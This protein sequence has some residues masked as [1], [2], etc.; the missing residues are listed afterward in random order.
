MSSTIPG[1][2]FDLASDHLARW[3]G[4]DPR[5]VSAGISLLELAVTD[6]ITRPPAPEIW[7]KALE[8]GT[9]VLARLLELE[10]DSDVAGGLGARLAQCLSA[11]SG[12][13]LLRAAKAWRHHG[14]HPKS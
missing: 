14:H 1:P 12:D 3:D 8:R 13:N 9:A 6:I 7:A 4:L 5:T 10:A 2:F 11:L